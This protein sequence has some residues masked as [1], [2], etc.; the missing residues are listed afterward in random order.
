MNRYANE[1]EELPGTGGELAIHLI[2]RFELEGVK[3]EKPA[4]TTI[5]STRLPKPYV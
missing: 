4:N 1:I 5:N 3:V 2:K